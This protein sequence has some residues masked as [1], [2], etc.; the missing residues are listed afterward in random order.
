LLRRLSVFA[1]GWILSAAEI[2]CADDDLPAMDVLDVLDR[3][4][5]S[6]LVVVDETC[7]R[8]LETI[9][10]YA[11]ARL[12][13]A[14]EVDATMERLNGW[15]STLAHD[16][17]PRVLTADASHVFVMLDREIDN[18]RAV[19]TWLKDHER[20]NELAG[21][22]DALSWWSIEHR[23]PADA[24]AWVTAVLDH[25]P[26]VADP[27][28]ARLLALRAMLHGAA[29]RPAA[30]GEDLLMAARDVERADP[31]TRY[32]YHYASVFASAGNPRT[33]LT[34]A[35]QLHE[36]VDATVEHLTRSHDGRRTEQVRGWLRASAAMTESFGYLMLDDLENWRAAIAT[37][38][39]AL[40][41]SA[42]SQALLWAGVHRASFGLHAADYVMG[43]AGV[44]LVRR[45]SPDFGD[46]YSFN[47]ARAIGCLI[48]LETGVDTADLGRLDEL[49]VGSRADGH[50]VA[51]NQLMMARLAQLGS[52]GEFS[53]AIELAAGLHEQAT[54]SG[55]RYAEQLLAL[56]L[57]GL[58]ESSA[59]LDAA[60][61]WL[62]TARAVELD[63]I[64]HRVAGLLDLREAS[65]A[66]CSGD[67][68]R[69][70]D[71]THA[72]ATT[73][74]SHG[75]RRE[76]VGT[77]EL[78]ACLA[79]S[80]ERWTEV[81]RFH[82]AAERLRDELGYRFRPAPGRGYVERVVAD[83]TNA[84]NRDDYVDMF[85]QGRGLSGSDAVAYAQRMRGQRGR[86]SAG[87]AALTPTEY[88]VVGL[89]AEGL[90]N[91][92]IGERLLMGRETVKSHLASIYRKVSV[93]SRAALT[94][95]YLE[96]RDRPG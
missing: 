22:C 12:R 7:F 50:P 52:S 90:T 14:G 72:A 51:T 10:Q 26:R 94:R 61:H 89:V 56:E 80:N 85:E 83:A 21:L 81:A 39:Q 20:F 65:L 27:P 13:D 47:I 35:R 67:L 86:P 19:C 91:P 1:G 33:C 92:Q 93:T 74:V 48:G 95:R 8:L 54:A 4:V 82:G 75:F 28:F 46:D 66:L 68:D 15:V 25:E 37:M 58:Y 57:A 44:D 42:S 55:Q 24:L 6:S 2:V 53:R 59:D 64:N 16:L 62:Q 87:W 36:L 34:H 31:L 40:Q 96:R 29:G 17:G 78:F 30:A 3:L 32:T 63:P 88:Q 5:T 11:A 79:G 43:T 18:I 77:F 9:R 60:A 45:L 49:I 76:L 69:A 38:D 23:D 73:Q 70:D 41:G 84:L 71:L